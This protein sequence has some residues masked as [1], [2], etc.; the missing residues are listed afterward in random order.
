M[1]MKMKDK[2]ALVITFLGV[3]F[4]SVALPNSS[5]NKERGEDLPATAEQLKEIVRETPCAM[6]L[7]R[8]RLNFGANE[9]SVLSLRVAKSIALNCTKSERQA[10]IKNEREIENKKT[11]DMQLDALSEIN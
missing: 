6:K 5:I 4:L 11:H 7:F 3:V 9:H 10:A 8:E 2:L 1:K